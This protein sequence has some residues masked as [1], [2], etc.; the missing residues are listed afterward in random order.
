MSDTHD[1]VFSTVVE[2]RNVELTTHWARFN[3]HLLLNG[4][5]LVALLSAAD[6]SKIRSLGKAPYAFGLVFAVLWFCSEL[7][8]RLSLHHRDSQISAFEKNLW[9][10][11][12]LHDYRFFR[13]IPSSLRLQM[14]V[15]F[16][17]IATT[18]FG[19]VF[20]LCKT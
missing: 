14:F 5:F 7:V 9:K 1:E 17:L 11:T 20:L 6:D 12:T 4:G 2:T 19:W 8:G 10:D 16:L 3:S 15:S 18:I 13:N